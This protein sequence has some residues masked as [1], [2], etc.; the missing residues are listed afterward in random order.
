MQIIRLN[1]RAFRNLNDIQFEPDAGFNVIHG[2]NAQGKTNLLEGIFLIAALKSFR[3][4]RNGD[5]IQW[6]TDLAELEAVVE[7]RGVTRTLRVVVERSGRSV[8]LDGKRVQRIG[9]YFGHVN[10]VLFVPEDLAITKGEPAL[11]RRFLD[12]AV[13][14]TDAG[15][16][17]L[18]R[19]YDGAL[20]NRNAILREA[21]GSPSME[22]LGAFDAPLARLAAKV[23]ERRT[24]FL[25]G[26][27]PHFRAAFRGI[28]SEDVDVGLRYRSTCWGPSDADDEERTNEEDDSATD[29]VQGVRARL[30]RA[31][32]TDLNRS[33][34]SV[35]PH[36]DDL[37]A[38]LDGRPVRRFASQG[39]HRAFVL[40]LKV[41]EID[42]LQEVCGFRPVLLLDDVSSELDAVRGE[43]FLRLIEARGGQVFVTTTRRE[44]VGLTVRTRHWHMAQGALS[45]SPQAEDAIEPAPTQEEVARATTD[46]PDEEHDNG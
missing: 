26:F 31:L 6:G 24:A 36:M 32:P 45:G 2:Q 14:N 33:Y 5:L 34:T 44:L 38:T 13:F 10:V 16:I 28:T 11:R 40:A 23:V 15:Y 46:E 9:E 8:W 1:L 25:E 21:I 18:V 3:G 19:E 30:L 4:A 27:L 39:Q 20:R 12:R 37:V 17:D 22:V 7:R 35:G 29:L 43:R 41:A 42:Y